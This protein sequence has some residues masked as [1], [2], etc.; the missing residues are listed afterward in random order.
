MKAM[1]TGL[2]KAR[3]PERGMVFMGFSW[4]FHGIFTQNVDETDGTGMMDGFHR[5]FF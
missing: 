5:D 1:P 4:D 3:P 2:K